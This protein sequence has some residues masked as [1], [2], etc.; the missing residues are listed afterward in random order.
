[1]LHVLCDV[2]STER[3]VFDQYPR[4]IVKKTEYIK[5]EVWRIT[6]LSFRNSNIMFLKMSNTPHR[7]RPR[8]HRVTSSEGM[9]EGFSVAHGVDPH[10]AYHRMPPEDKY[11]DFRNETVSLM[12]VVGIPVKY[13]HHEVA[14]SA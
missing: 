7:G 9:G 1:M 10:K 8:N 11:M 13:H 5:K 14:I 12:E 2:V 4:N 3:E 6:P